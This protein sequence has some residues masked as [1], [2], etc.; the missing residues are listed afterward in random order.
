MSSMSNDPRF[1]LLTL[2]NETS[3]YSAA[4]IRRSN[5]YTM[6]LLLFNQSSCIS[7]H[8]LVCLNLD[9]AMFASLDR[10]Y[11]MIV[12]SGQLMLHASAG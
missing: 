1:S 8:A 5:R 6:K 9:L 7:L 3:M 10:I 11:D 4:Q 2:F 12:H